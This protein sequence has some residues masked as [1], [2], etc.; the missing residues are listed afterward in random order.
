MKIIL[1]PF[2][3][4]CLAIITLASCKSAGII[5]TPIENIDNI[6]LKVSELSEDQLKVWGHLDLAKDTIPGMSVDRAYNEIIKNKKGQTTIVAVI[7]T[8]IDIDHEDLNDVV[9]TNPGEIPN[10]GKDDDQNG[11]LDDI[12]GWNFLGDA[13]EEQLEYVRL[14]ASGETT[15][16]RYQEAQ[17]E[18]EREY[19][20]NLN[21]KTQSEQIYQAIKNADDIISKHLGKK[22]YTKEEVDAIV[23]KTQAMS[24]SVYIIQQTYAFGV[25]TVA[26]ALDAIKSDLN[27]LNKILNYNLNKEFKGRTTNDDI[28]NLSDTNYGNNNVKPIVEDESHGSHVAGIIAAERDNNIG[29]KGVANNVKIMSLRVVSNGD[30]YDKDVALAIRYAADNG[31]KVVNMSFGKYY[32]PHSEWVRDA[33]VYAAKKDVLLVTGAGNESLNLDQKPNY[34][35][36]QIDNGPE[37]SDN[38]LTVGALNPKYG[39]E[40]VA[41]Y[42]NYGKINVDV[43]APGSDIYSTFPNNEYKSISGTSMASPGVAGVAALIRSQY[44][45]LTASQVKHIIMSSG[46]TLTPKVIVGGSPNN[47]KPLN[48][49]SKSGKIVNAYNALIMASKL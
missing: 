24:Q 17:A 26:E 42:S 38:Y 44:P 4:L 46:L 47:I 29:A 41:D 12:H 32:S 11:Y 3:F 36:D 7:D 34:P 48:E 15:N 30:E 13:Y 27:E 14:L 19:Q 31:A 20:E 10:N 33:I 6:P 21:I 49:L 37:I 18:Y 16:P 45:H 23:P 5:S 22:D 9:W 25:K 1:K 8:G 35:S 2:V 28:N 43:F 39:A 40:M